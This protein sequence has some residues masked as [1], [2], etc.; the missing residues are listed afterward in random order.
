MQSEELKKYVTEI[1]EQ[2]KLSGV[3]QDIKDKL[4]DDLTNRLQEQIN[5]A[6]INALND[7]QFKEFEKLVDA[8]DAEKD[9]KST[10]LNSS[11]EFV[12]RMPSSA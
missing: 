2:K 7:E 11:H 12:S 3:D 6:L 8:E 9:R 10:R 4:I 5:R 1:I